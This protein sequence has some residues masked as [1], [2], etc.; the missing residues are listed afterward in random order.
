MAVVELIPLPPALDMDRLIDLALATCASIQTRR[1]YKSQLRKFIATGLP[2]NRE[3]VA[4]HLQSQRDAGKGGST[5]LSAM[6]AIRKLCSEAHIRGLMST[7]ELG[8][9][10]A[11]PI[12]RTYKPS[13]GVWMTVEQAQAF[14]ELPD[15]ATY[16]G[17]RD[18][19]LL[20]IMMGCGLRRAEMASVPWDAYHSRDGR[21][22]LHVLGKGRKV[23]TLPVPT[24]A[25]ADIE[26]WRETITTQ[27]PPP[28]KWSRWEN[29]TPYRD[30]GKPLDKSLIM[31]GLSGNLLYNLVA[32]YGKRLDL[33]L[34]PHDL[35]RTLAQ[36]MRK[37][38]CM[39]EQIQYTLGHE[40]IAT[41]ILYLGSKL[42]LSPGVAAVDS[43][44]LTAGGY[45]KSDIDRI[46]MALEAERE[47]Q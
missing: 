31:G 35:R 46:T 44:K 41:T 19:C 20:S 13:T 26:A 9:I 17:R 21:M 42:E 25:Y 3:G 30:G 39:L 1:M 37:A 45:S 47:S 33:D 22:C 18:A 16:W 34:S 29:L 8:Q 27:S 2:L 5:L 38:G 28:L 15:R 12:G 36:L 24:W 10:N 14:L 4:L 40:D 11:I 7:D 32:T 23:R 6:A 43:L